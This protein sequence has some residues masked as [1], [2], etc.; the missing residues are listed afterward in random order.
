MKAILAAEDNDSP[1]DPITIA[2]PSKTV[3]FANHMILGSQMELSEIDEL[4]KRLIREE[5]GRAFRLQA[6]ASMDMWLCIKRAISSA[7]HAKKA[8][9]DGRAKVT[10]AGK[11]LQDQAHLLKD[12]QAAERQVKASEAKL[13]EMRAALDAAVTAA[14]DAEAAKEAVQ[15]ALED[16]ERAKTAEIDLAVREA[17]RGYRSSEEFTVLLDRKVGSHR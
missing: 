2:C 15:T 16:S 3:Q 4:S 10:E 1:A 5:A 17:I 9:E 8:Y 11:A 14:I 13:A 7:E 6:S 12:K